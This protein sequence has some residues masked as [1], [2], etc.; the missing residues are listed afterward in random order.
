MKKGLLMVALLLMPVNALA[1]TIRVAAAAD[2]VYAMREIV[3]L[4]KAQG[5][6]EVK[7]SLGSSGNFYRQIEH[8]APFGLFF[9]ASA[10]YINRL[11]TK[12]CR[13]A[14]YA[15]G[16]LVL[17]VPVGSPIKP[18]NS[19]QYFASELAQHQAWKF[20]IANPE[21]APY[22]MVAK[23]TLQS[24]QVWDQFNGHLVLGENAAQAA[25]F[26]ISGSTVGGLIPLSIAISDAFRKKGAYRLIDQKKHVQLKQEMGLLTCQHT[27]AKRFFDFMSMPQV[28]K[29][30][31][32]Y[33]FQLPEMRP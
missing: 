7:I 13:R 24:E 21:H 5:G 20:A 9:S 28:R 29:V 32:T 30:L 1:E 10:D 19:L 15:S 25:Q 16:R 26:A 27:E 14:P 8:G 17:F 18:T 12:V 11:G 2:L 23:E 33:G 6:S 4:W 31:H 22:G 3:S